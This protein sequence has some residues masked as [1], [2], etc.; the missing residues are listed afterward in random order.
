MAQVVIALGSN[1]GNRAS[2]LTQA[3]AFLTTLSRRPLIISSIYE[4]EPVGEAS[5]KMYYNAVC[6]METTLPPLQLLDRL[7]KYE[8]DYG[9]DP[10][11]PRWSNRTIDLDIIDYN[12]Q[13]I[14]ED[15]FRVPHPHYAER[16]F[17]LHPLQ[18]IFPNW[19]DLPSGKSI[20]TLIASA[21]KIEVFKKEVNW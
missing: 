11:A 4:T 7:K 19:E 8:Q 13:V 17:V 15:T 20:D 14:S 18:E 21:P 3:K 12:R 2:H 16:L 1:L 5:T 10:T 6:A 9:R